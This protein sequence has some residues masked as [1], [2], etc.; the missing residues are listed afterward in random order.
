VRSLSFSSQI[1][2]YSNP[3]EIYHSIFKLLFVQPIS[4]SHLGEKYLKQM[5]ELQLKLARRRNLNGEEV[6][7]SQEEIDSLN[8]SPVASI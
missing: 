5:N 1:A 2:I 8:A 6:Q 4:S 3:G 7:L